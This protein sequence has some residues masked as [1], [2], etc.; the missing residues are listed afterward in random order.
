MSNVIIIEVQL[1]QY[2]RYIGIT[3]VTKNTENIL[4]LHLLFIIFY[5]IIMK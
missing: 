4:Y 5:I 1:Q 2:F 3:V